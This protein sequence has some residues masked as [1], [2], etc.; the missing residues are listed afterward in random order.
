LRADVQHD[1]SRTTVTPLAQLDAAGLAA[2]YAPM[3]EQARETLV[4]EGFPAETQV[5]ASS[6]DVRYAGQEHTVTVPVP[7]GVEDVAATVEREFVELHER[8]YGHRMDDPIEVTTLRLRATGVVDRPSLPRLPRREDGAPAP[9]GTRA[10]YVSEAEPALPYALYTREALL[11][12]DQIDGPAVIAEHTATTVIHT[13]DR[14]RVGE[15]G[16]LVITVG[17]T[18]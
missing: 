16:E 13:G 11:A 8:Q 3:I 5:L 18:A 14:L 4:A 2:S 1:L 7:D 17:G 12:G 10:V 15:H 6:V 9:N